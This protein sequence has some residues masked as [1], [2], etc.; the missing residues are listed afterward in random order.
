[1]GY[2]SGIGALSLDH[3]LEGNILV[4][5]FASMSYYEDD[6][7]EQYEEYC[8]RYEEEILYV[9]GGLPKHECDE[10]YWPS[11]REYIRYDSPIVK[12]YLK[13]MIESCENM[14]YCYNKYLTLGKNI[15][16]VM[17]L[18]EYVYIRY[19]FFPQNLI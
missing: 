5:K 7:D 17:Y 3:H 10:F 11:Y 19:G 16:T 18:K 12:K 8:G 9:D 2:Y 6:Y 14:P 4:N 15:G 13:N 1:M